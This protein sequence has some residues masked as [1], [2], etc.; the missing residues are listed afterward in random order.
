[1]NKFYFFLIALVINFIYF[2][3]EIKHNPFDSQKYVYGDAIEYINSSESFYLGNGFV[4]EDLKNPNFHNIPKSNFI[5]AKEYDKL[6]YYAYRSPGVAFFYYPLRIFFNQHYTILLI[7][8]LQ[9]LLNAYAKVVLSQMTQILLKD[10]NYFYFTFIFV[11]IFPYFSYMNTRLMTESLAM[12]TLIFS[13]FFILKFNEYKYSRLIL[14]L[15]GF[16][17][18]I[19]VMLRPFLAIFF[20]LIVFLYNKS[21]LKLTLINGLVFLSSFIV[22]NGIW[23]VRT[24]L[25]TNEFIVIAGTTKYISQKNKIFKEFR[26]IL[27]KHRYNYCEW[28]ETSPIYWMNHTHYYDSNLFYRHQN[29]DTNL[30][31]K[32]RDH[33][34]LSKNLELTIKERQY[35]ESMGVKIVQEF[36][37]NLQTNFKDKILLYL[38]YFVNFFNQ[39][40]PSS[41]NP[42][43]MPFY[44]IFL[45]LT[46]LLFY[47]G[48][49]LLLITY[50]N[51]KLFILNLINLILIIYMLYGGVIE[52]RRL[53]LNSFIFYINVVYMIINLTKLK[54]TM[55]H[56]EDDN[57]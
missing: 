5:P 21:N 33:Y 11:N 1:M 55:K 39:P 14:F 37:N 36:E 17:L 20:L 54:L 6:Q 34:Q 40:H 26:I 41:L 22:I 46:R 27:N 35:H 49:F 19:S 43:P 18:C 30:L 2:F 29:I 10:K 7:I 24:Y 56:Y 31:Y 3:T 15:S 4:F 28:Q 45:F 50:K 53:Y 47:L 25:K 44:H 13:I 9:I 42:Y 57:S 12:S 51:K 23:T 8:F 48:F 32:I 38:D 52:K 16:L